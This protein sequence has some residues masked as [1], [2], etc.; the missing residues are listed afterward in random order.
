MYNMLLHHPLYRFR[1]NRVRMGQTFFSVAGRRGGGGIAPSPGTVSVFW[2]ISRF[3][4]GNTSTR[5]TR[6]FRE[7][8]VS[9][10][11]LQQSTAVIRV[12]DKKNNNKTYL[13]CEIPD[14]WYY[15][16]F[17]YNNISYYYNILYRMINLLSVKCNKPYDDY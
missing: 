12:G 13:C 1:T 4:P 14:V 11:Y 9:Y 6:G 3:P 8:R 17:V 16:I 10:H 5:I 2:A 15:M 7:F